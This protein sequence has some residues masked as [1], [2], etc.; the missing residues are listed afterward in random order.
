MII[1]MLRLGEPHPSHFVMDDVL[2]VVREFKPLKTYLV[3]MNHTVD[4]NEV[5]EL[6]EIVK[7]EE[8]LHI[9]LAFDGLKVS[10]PFTSTW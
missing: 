5:N 3:G 6:L 9:E 8:Q 2:T 10:V 7:K 4:H 1:D